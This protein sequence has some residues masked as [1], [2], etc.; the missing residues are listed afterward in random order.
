VELPS[1]VPDELADLIAGR[2]GLLSEPMRNRLFDRLRAGEATVHDLAAELGSSQQNV[3]RHLALMTDGGLL[4]RRKDGN[5]VY[6]R[7]GDESVIALC[8]QVRASIGERL[9]GTHR[10]GDAPHLA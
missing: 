3:S 8:E 10:A 9:A 1:P 2:F 7:I 5:C 4:A 6:Y